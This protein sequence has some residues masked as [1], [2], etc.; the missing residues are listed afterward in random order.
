M[1]VFASMLIAAIPDLISAFKK[2]TQPTSQVPE[3]SW[4]RVI[5][6]VLKDPEAMAAIGVAFR[7]IETHVQNHVVSSTVPGDGSL[8]PTTGEPSVLPAVPGGHGAR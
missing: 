6:A 2:G 5:I 4:T 7:A 1:G 3:V 8:V